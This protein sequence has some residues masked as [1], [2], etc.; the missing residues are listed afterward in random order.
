MKRLVKITLTALGLSL[1]ACGGPSQ[2]PD[3][4]V[5]ATWTSGDDDPL[6]TPAGDEE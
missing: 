5:S 4:E 1:A 6:E 2:P 3:E